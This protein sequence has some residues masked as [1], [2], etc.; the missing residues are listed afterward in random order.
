MPEDAPSKK[1]PDKTILPYGPKVQTIKI[2]IETTQAKG[3]KEKTFIRHLSTTT[4]T[5]LTPYKYLTENEYKKEEAKETN[6]KKDPCQMGTECK[7]DK[8]ITNTQGAPKTKI[9][10]EHKEKIAE[11]EGDITTAKREWTPGYIPGE[12]PKT[13]KEEK[14]DA[15]QALRNSIREKP[16]PSIVKLVRTIQETRGKKKRKEKKK[17]TRKVGRP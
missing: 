16:G 6:R 4:T 11:A 7:Q 14:Y 2:P 17:P 15:M 13:E 1:P 8:E 10:W 9:N 5:P 3:I 12:E